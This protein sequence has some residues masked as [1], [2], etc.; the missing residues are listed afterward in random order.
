M[1]LIVRSGNATNWLNKAM[2]QQNKLSGDDGAATSDDTTTNQ[3]TTRQF[4]DFLTEFN[5]MDA[6]HEVVVDL[7][8]DDT[9]SK[10]A[11]SL[12]S[13]LTGLLKGS[14]YKQRFPMEFIVTGE[15]GITVTVKKR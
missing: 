2:G 6:N 11:A 15:T 3:P 14:P 12:S 10:Q 5:D 1:N 8:P 7:M 4:K 9:S 13:R